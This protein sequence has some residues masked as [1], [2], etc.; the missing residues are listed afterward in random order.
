MK[1]IQLIS[2]INELNKVQVN[3]YNDY[4]KLLKAKRFGVTKVRWKDIDIAIC[5]DN[6]GILKSG[7]L[8]RNVKG[9]PLPLFGNMVICGGVDVKGNPFDLPESIT[10]EDVKERI[11]TPLYTIK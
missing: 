2:G 6:Y 3:S 9:C 4:Y 5:M 7:N 8:G 10:I 1:A 11:S